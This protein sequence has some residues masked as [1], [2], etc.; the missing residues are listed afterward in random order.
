M[1]QEV[2]VGETVHVM[3][4]GICA[5]WDTLVLVARQIRK[6]DLYY[7]EICIENFALSWRKPPVAKRNRRLQFKVL[8][9]IYKSARPRPKGSGVVLGGVIS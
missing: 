3:Y 9:A 8:A 1:L 2:A 6:S 7:V 4:K 5:E